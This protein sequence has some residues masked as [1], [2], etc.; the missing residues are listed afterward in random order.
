MPNRRVMIDT[1][2][3]NKGAEAD[4]KAL[5]AKAKATAKEVSSIDKQIGKSNTS[6]QKIGA[7]LEKARAKAGELR[8]ELAKVNEQL[9]VA[10]R[11]NLTDIQMAAPHL[12]AA[13]QSSMAT[14]RTIAQN[15]S[16]IQQSD[17][18]TSK[19][20]AQEAS[21][22]TLNSQYDEN[23]A[24]IAQLESQKSGLITRLE[25]E[26]QSITDMTNA[27]AAQQAAEAQQMAYEEQQAAAQERAQAAS[28]RFSEA[29]SGAVRGVVGLGK[30]AAS[31]FGKIAAGI[32]KAMAR[33]NPFN[34]TFS[35]FSGRMREILTGALLFN[36]ISAAIRGCTSYLSQAVKSSEAFRGALANLKGAAATAAAPIVQALTPAITALANA[37][38]VAMGYIAKLV[39]FFTGKSIS[40]M[41]SAAKAMGAY[42][43]A[44]KKARNELAGFDEINKLGSKDNSGAVA[45]NYDFIPATSELG[46]SIMDAIKAGDWEG[47]GKI[48]AD[49]LNEVVSKF[50]AAGW[51]AKLGKV[52]QHGIDVASEFI[53]NVDWNA[54]GE[55]AAQFFNSALEQIDGADVG[56]ILVS[57]FTIGLRVLGSFLA[58]IDWGLLAQKVSEGLISALNDIG[59]AIDSVD[60]QKLG[61]G[62]ANGI[63]SIDYVGIAEAIGYLFGQALKAGIEFVA[64]AG[65]D[66]WNWIESSFLEGFHMVFDEPEK[67]AI[68]GENIV[69]GIIVGIIKVMCDIGVW[70]WENIFKP[71]ADG[72][73]DAFD[74]H[75]PSRVAEGWGENIGLGMLGGLTAAWTRITA[76]IEKMRQGFAQGWQSIKSSTVSVFNSLSATLGSIWSGIVSTIRGAVNTI[77]SAIN[78]MIRGVC[79][80]VNGAID[81]LNGFSFDVPQWA[82]DTL[83]VSRIGFNISRINA[84]QIPYLAQGAVIPPN[85]EFLAVLGDQTGGTNIEAPLETIQAAFNGSMEPFIDYMMQGLQAVVEAI[86]AKDTT[87]C[88]GDDQLARSRNRYDRRMAIIRGTV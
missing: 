23:A 80:G 32:K 35:F 62:I 3:N 60:W 15:A 25:Q 9:E 4:L 12:S 46:E 72:I 59:N 2:I 78:G 17:R 73:A 41:Q 13:E 51:G 52:L 58:N 88:I 31:A 16:L 66:L 1:R 7:D 77:I 75:S 67:W 6:G 49:K 5:E 79:S 54:I 40:S 70:I 71:F 36:G 56:T 28:E 27:I 29:V 19:L 57:K 43:D 64:G 53:R 69:G 26:R 74:M 14:A 50:D 10:Q 8:D 34:K 20:D 65:A 38:A 76:F 84:P 63:R 39:S 47:V 18:L 21:V 44:T 42:G 83:G 11:K 30:I 68:F 86:E 22:A 55:K 81:V 33:M 61:T 45:P 37:A 82:R 48:L 24:T 87:V 85:R